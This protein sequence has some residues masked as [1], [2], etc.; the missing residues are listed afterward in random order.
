MIL[1]ADAMS[2]APDVVVEAV[3]ESCLL[4]SAATRISV[5]NSLVVLLMKNFLMVVVNFRA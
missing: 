3:M 4:V 2:L 5:V 1:N